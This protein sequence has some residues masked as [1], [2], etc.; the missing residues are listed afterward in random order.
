MRFIGAHLERSTLRRAPTHQRVQRHAPAYSPISSSPDQPTQAGTESCGL[1]ELT[2]WG[3]VYTGSGNPTADRLA[4]CGARD[5]A[6]VVVK[7][8]E[9]GCRHLR[10][11]LRLPPMLQLVL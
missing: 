7:P 8:L 1:S 2:K 6:L 5:C 4:T 10:D 11:A 3:I 9:L